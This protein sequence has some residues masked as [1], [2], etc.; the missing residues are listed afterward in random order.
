MRQPLTH[1]LEWEIDVPLLTNRH[2]VSALAKVMLGTAAIVAALVGL[3]LGIQGDWQLI[4]HVAGL[5]FLLG[6][7][8]FATGLLVMAFPFRNRLATRFTLDADSV[9]MQVI[10]R[11]AQAGSRL[12]FWAGLALGSAATAGSSMLAATQ[13]EQT[14]HWNGAFRVAFGPAS[15]SI[16]FR[17]GWRTLMRVYCLPDNYDAAVE[18]VSRQMAQH[19]TASR[20]SAR[21]PIGAYLSRT[22]LILLASLPLFAI[23]DIYGFSLLPPFLL[24]C[25]GVAMVWF[26]RQLAWGVLGLMVIISALVLSGA[27]AERTS[28]IGHAAYLRY[29]TLSG[30]DWA[31]TVLAIAGAAVIVWLAIATL[32]E[33]IKPALTQDMI[34]AGE[35]S[36]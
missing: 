34:D 28:Y 1:P 32:R 11:T 2:M 30:D 14:L 21:S 23:S 3:L 20:V 13:Q 16:A 33:K 27:Y 4:P 18:L 6:C 10:D 36:E 15:R 24:L 12:G 22:L 25:F 31:L 5:L 19:G 29:E 9:R 7:A 17:N 8:L 26:V 35:A